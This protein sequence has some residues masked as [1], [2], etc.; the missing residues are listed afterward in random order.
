[1]GRLAAPAT[2]LRWHRDIVRRRWARLSC[3]GHSGRPPTRRNVRSVVLRLARENEPWGYS[4]IHGEL[5][6]LGIAVVPSTVWQ[7]LKKAHERIVPS[8]ADH[9]RAPR[10]PPSAALSERKHVRFP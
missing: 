2:M 1:M 9:T 10:P 6:A 7:F 5:V 3:R 4:R 8:A